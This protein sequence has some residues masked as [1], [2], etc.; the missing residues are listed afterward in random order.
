MVAEQDGTDEPWTPP[1]QDDSGYSATRGDLA[2]LGLPEQDVEAFQ[3]GDY[4][5]GM[6]REDW[7]LFRKSFFEALDEDGVTHADVRLKGSS[8]GF[9]AGPHKR[10]PAN[11]RE[12]V[13]EF[14]KAYGAIPE[15]WQRDKMKETLR[16]QWPLGG[17]TPLRRPFNAMYRLR[18][19]RAPSDYDLQISSDE[20]F[21]RGAAYVKSEGLSDL[22]D[23]IHPTYAFMLKE[24]FAKVCKA[25]DEWRITA[26]P[27]LR[28]DITIAAFPSGGPPN[29]ENDPDPRKRLLS[30]H[31]RTTDWLVARDGT[32]AEEVPA[33]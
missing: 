33:P 28:F 29:Y 11:E 14:R 20:I 8:A 26:S 13:D 3:R 17:H 9:Y 21:A 27:F 19:H 32:W 6:S 22:V 1:L 23:L 16:L 31:H 5:L 24:V 12:I 4:P 25:T 30:S 7:N 15:R 18:I 10:M 2:F